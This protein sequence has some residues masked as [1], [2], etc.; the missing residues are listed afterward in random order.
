MSTM[1]TRI[2]VTNP[3]DYG[4]DYFA[5]ERIDHRYGWSVP[6][7]EEIGLAELCGPFATREEA[8]AAIDEVLQ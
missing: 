3:A 4:V 6:A 1:S 7:W 8:Q 2:Q 5:V